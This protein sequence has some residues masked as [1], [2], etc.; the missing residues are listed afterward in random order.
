MNDVRV[1]N[2]TKMDCGTKEMKKEQGLKA[3]DKKC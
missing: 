2:T 1:L 3:K